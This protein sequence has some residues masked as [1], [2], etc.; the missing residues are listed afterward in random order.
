MICV[1][2]FTSY[3]YGEPK[4]QK[5]VPDMAFFEYLADMVE[6]DA[7]LLGPLDIKPITVNT[8]PDT[9]SSKVKSKSDQSQI[10]K[11]D[12]RKT[13]HNTSEDKNNG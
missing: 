12:I 5:K 1:V 11:T 4:N 7:E 6:V 10:I 3:T 9:A 8:L 2:V 13:K